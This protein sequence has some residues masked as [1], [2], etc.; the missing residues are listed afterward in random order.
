MR[1]RILLFAA[2]LMQVK[3]IHIINK[4][5]TVMR[6]GALWLHS[7]LDVCVCELR[8]VNARQLHFQEL[9]SFFHYHLCKISA[10]I[11]DMHNYS[12]L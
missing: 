3:R 1:Q 10:Q 5:N 12:F 4:M 8:Q 2:I 11:I 7:S 9:L 6:L